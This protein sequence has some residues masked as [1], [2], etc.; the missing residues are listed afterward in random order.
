MTYN[1]YAI[2]VHCDGA[3]NYDS[4][5]SG[6]IGYVIIFPENIELEPI[7]NSVGKFVGANIE[8]LELEAIIQGMEEI[9]RLSKKYSAQFRKAN[10]IIIT[11]DRFA[12]NDEER[13]NPHRI[14]QWR[15]NRWHNHEGKPIKNSDL[16]DKLDKNRKKLVGNLHC[17]VNIQY[18]RRKKNKPAD[19][20]AKAGKDF[21]LK[22]DNIA[23]KGTKPAKRLFEGLLIDYKKLNKKEELII[24][25]YRKEPVREAWE[26]FAEVCKGKFYGYKLKIYAED[27][28][29]SR[30]QRQH[31][32]RVKIK[33]VLRYHINVYGQIYDYKNKTKLLNLTNAQ[34]FRNY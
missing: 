9:L 27:R 20:L 4:N 13:T 6:G 21:P 10:H 17:R 23:I 30:L 26:I 19:K 15:K 28:L 11:T 12:L 2:Y 3:M 7:T 25:I 24:H 32:Y 31:I 18:E 1:P 33:D 34:H 5:S 29:A 8:R 16:L 14:R 22:K